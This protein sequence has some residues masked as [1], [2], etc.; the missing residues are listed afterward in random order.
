MKRV[1]TLLVALV[2]ASALP[3]ASQDDASKALWNRLRTLRLD[4]DFT[5]TGLP[6]FVDYLREVAD[7]NIVLSPKAELPKPFTIKAR[8]V[9]IS[10]LLRLLL[11][12]QRLG[13][14]IEDGVLLIVPDAEL[15]SAVRLEIIDVRDLLLPIRD[16]PGIEITLNTDA[17]GVSMVEADDDAKG[18]FPIVDLL[19]AH[20]GGKTWD[21]NPRASIQLMNGLLF[22]R[23][24]DEVIQQIRRILASLRR[25][26]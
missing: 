19:K 12:P 8:S 5:N 14:K 13:W 6:E 15:Q 23:Q 25:F 9:T 1:A 7:I 18:E 24:T 2:A 3:A 21:E 11:K 10:S 4:V 17:A 20:V 22:V 26:K 16:F